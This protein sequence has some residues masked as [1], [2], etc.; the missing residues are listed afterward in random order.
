[1]QSFSFSLVGCYNTTPSQVTWQDVDSTMS[2]CSAGVQSHS[3]S[4]SLVCCHNTTLSQVAWQDVDSTVSSCS[5]GTCACY[6]PSHMFSQSVSDCAPSTSWPCSNVPK[7]AIMMSSSSSRSRLLLSESC[8][9]AVLR[10]VCAMHSCALAGSGTEQCCVCHWVDVSVRL[11]LSFS[12][13]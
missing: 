13:N 1:M 9:H 4:L 8:V 7:K 5:A 10:S 2:S 11:V 12:N 6:N 3:F